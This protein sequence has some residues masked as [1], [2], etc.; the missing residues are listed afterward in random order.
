MASPG[1]F[2]LALTALLLGEAGLAATPP[3][4]GAQPSPTKE[5]MLDRILRVSA[6]NDPKASKPAQE[7]KKFLGGTPRDSRAG[8]MFPTQAFTGAGTFATRDYVTAPY[9]EA[10]KGW[11]ARMFPRK[12]LPPNLQGEARDASRRFDTGSYATKAFS[13]GGKAD[14]YAGR[15]G[16]PTRDFR[17]RGKAQGGIDA[18]IREAVKKGLSL[19]DVRKLLNN[20]P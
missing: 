4:A 18:T 20:P 9:R 13:P 16:Y 1:K 12:D 17:E 8:M 14:P 19:D 2:L 11:L 6:W 3:A 15:E 10:G 5:S 7:G